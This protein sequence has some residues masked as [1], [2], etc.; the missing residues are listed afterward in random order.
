MLA[1]GCRRQS[2]P[3]A[4]A[5][6]GS[7]GVTVQAARVE[8]LRDV[9][10]ASGTIVPLAA[11]DWTIFAPENAEITELPVKEGDTVAAG[12]VLVRF[13]IPS[14]TQ[15]MSTLQLDLIEATARL[16][17]AKADLTRKTALFE[18]GITSRNDYDASRV[19]QSTAESLVA[20][21]RTRLQALQSADD[22]SLV[23]ARFAGTILKVWHA[24]R[25]TVSAATDPVLRIV[26]PTRVQVS[27]QLPVA[28]L[29]R[30]VPGQTATIRAIAGAADEPATVAWKP[31]VSDASAPTGD[32]RLTFTKAATLPL[33]TPV[34]AEILLD[35]R[36]GALVVPS[37]SVKR[38][39]L[40]AFVMVV[41]G[42][43]RAHRHD[44][45]VGLVTRDLTQ[46]LSGLT[47]GDLL[48]VTGLEDV[49]EGTV[50]AV[51]R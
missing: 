6:G 19:E 17:R 1:T 51:G 50:V 46:I 44:V 31:D 18:R 24:P 21:A 28:Q 7:I 42:D 14:A 43:N 25:D 29:T 27:V 2:T 38:D 22:R 39:D 40:S 16:D 36:T 33:E 11:A 12:A 48:I 4:D 37:A 8:T 41:A 30:I 10:T 32:V 45:S 23:R 34:S 20:Q 5:A 26:D 15:E 35:Q 3:A 47:P 49:V 9:V 13:D